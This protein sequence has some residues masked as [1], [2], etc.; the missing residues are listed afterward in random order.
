MILAIVLWLLLALLLAAVLVLS[1]PVRVRLLAQS[2]PV[3]RVSLEL[4]L[5]GGL[6]PWIKVVD[7]ARP[8]APKPGAPK[9]ERKPKAKRKRAPGRARGLRMARAAP[10]LLRGLLGQIHLDRFH[11]NCV[12]GL[13]DPADTGRLFGLLAPIQYGTDWAWGRNVSIDM[14]PDFNRLCLD[15][16]ADVALAVTPL[17]LLPPAVRFAWA[18]FGVRR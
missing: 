3:R 10:R 8:A 17:R 6:V 2:G 18:T 4:G 5:L 7:T 13:D 9:P 14:R 16:N 15:G 12:F 11:V 1:L